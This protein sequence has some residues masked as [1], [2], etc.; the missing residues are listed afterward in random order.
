MKQQQMVKLVKKGRGK[1]G[2]KEV[3]ILD[4]VI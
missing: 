1:E 2:G 3:L 4:L